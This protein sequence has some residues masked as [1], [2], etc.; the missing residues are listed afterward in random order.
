MP[1]M[2]VNLYDLPFTT[3]DMERLEEQLQRQGISI[4]RALSPNREAILAFIREEFGDG[5]AGEASVALGKCP[6]SLYIAAQQ[7]RVVGFACFD[8]TAK[9]F[10][11][12]IGVTESLRG[13]QIGTALLCRCLNAMRQEGYGYA[14]I[15]GAGV[16]DFY[17]REANAAPIVGASIPTSVYSQMLGC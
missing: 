1:D 14:I 11:G 6:T 4:L 16:P 8:A 15:G 17:Q 10:F 9:D 12:P 13:H 3:Q 2:L 5:W 7:V